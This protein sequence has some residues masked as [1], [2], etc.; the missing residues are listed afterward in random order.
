MNRSI[1]VNLYLMSK[2]DTLPVMLRSDE[3]RLPDLNGRR[4]VL[5]G[6]PKRKRRVGIERNWNGGDCR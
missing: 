2:D 3:R 1:L 5:A 6:S 4:G